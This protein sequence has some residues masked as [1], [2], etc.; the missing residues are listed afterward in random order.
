MIGR[1]DDEILDAWIFTAG[2][3][4]V[5]CVWSGGRKVVAGGAHA[6]RERIAARFAAT[7]GRLFSR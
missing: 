7:M 4:A 2:G 5:D 6:A 3:R 1:T